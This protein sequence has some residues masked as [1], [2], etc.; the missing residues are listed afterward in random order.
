MAKGKVE[1]LVVR[2][3]STPDTGKAVRMLSPQEQ[4]QLRDTKKAAG[5][6]VERIL[7]T[8]QSSNE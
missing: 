4:E 8:T 5:A 1:S 7:K 3:P 6:Y 2:L